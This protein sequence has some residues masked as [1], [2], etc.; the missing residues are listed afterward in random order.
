MRSDLL[1]NDEEFTDAHKKYATVGETESDENPDSH[2]ICYVNVKDRL[3][4]F[5]NFN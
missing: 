3:Y 1:A 5:G 2:F 4:E